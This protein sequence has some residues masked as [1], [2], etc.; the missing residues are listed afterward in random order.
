MFL[1]G[2]MIL[3]VA[4]IIGSFL[5]VL[6]KRWPQGQPVALARSACPHCRHELAP[7]DM[8][9]ILSFLWLKGRCRYCGAPF[10]L[11]HLAIE[12]AALCVAVAVISADNGWPAWADAALGWALLTAAW[13]DAENFRLPDLITL[14]LILAGLLITWLEQPGALYNHAAAA[15]AAYVAFRL[16]D[17]LYL[18]LRDRHGLGAGDAKLLA[19]AG[20]WLGLAAL[21]YVVFG[22][23]VA[24]ILM[25]LLLSR[26]RLHGTL[27][28]PFGPALALSFF[29]IRL[30][31]S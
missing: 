3:L 10:G 26:G 4:P 18:R 31:G 14:P 15:A 8:V 1:S 29:L 30:W 21:P 27:R 19:A 23:A 17:V 22:A 12:L 11:F 16:I 28:L 13:I 25:A 6:I 7:L 2:W 20:A 5:G 9:P 24:G